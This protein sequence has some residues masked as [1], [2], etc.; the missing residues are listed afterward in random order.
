V[1]PREASA[2][3]ARAGGAYSALQ[4]SGRHAAA[5][6]GPRRRPARAGQ[7]LTRER[8]LRRRAASIARPAR[9]R[10]R[11]RNPCVFAR[12]RLFGWNV[13]LLTG[14]PGTPGLVRCGR[15]APRRFQD[16]A[17]R[18]RSVAGQEKRYAGQAP[19][20]KPLRSTA[21]F[22]RSVLALPSARV[23]LRRRPRR[24]AGSRRQ[25]NRTPR[26]RSATLAVCRTSAEPEP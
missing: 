9:V 24:S 19:L 26:A 1:M 22:I 18:A 25:P 12:R 8:P 10:M 15:L 23:A 17:K 20:V 7:T 21:P 3:T 13:R 2:V 16:I 11:S 14:T 5:P 4:A 6:A